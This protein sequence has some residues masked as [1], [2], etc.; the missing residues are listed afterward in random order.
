MS[1]K[2]DQLVREIAALIETTETLR[3]VLGRYKRANAKLSTRIARGE[4]VLEA[5]DGLEGTM[6]RQRE[7]TETLEEFDAARHQVRVALFALAT[8]QGASRSEIGRR[9]GISRQLAARLAS[10]VDDAAR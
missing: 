5:F 10:E 7:L 1:K 8:A 6:R 2:S 4:S 3:G 9:L